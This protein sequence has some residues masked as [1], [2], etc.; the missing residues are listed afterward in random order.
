MHTKRIERL[1]RQWQKR[2]RFGKDGNIIPYAVSYSW[3]WVAELTD[4]KKIH[5][6]SAKGKKNPPR[7]KTITIIYRN[8]P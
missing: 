1:H 2:E 7:F 3:G 5:L 6:P 8:Y 4:W